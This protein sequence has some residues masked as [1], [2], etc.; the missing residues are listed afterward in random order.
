MVCGLVVQLLYSL[1]EYL[2]TSIINLN[3]FY[4]PSPVLPSN[5]SVLHHEADSLPYLSRLYVPPKTK[6]ALLCQKSTIHL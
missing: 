1:S 2:F 3:G 5:P 4:L 6:I